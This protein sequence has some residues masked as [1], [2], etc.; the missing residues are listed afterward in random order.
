MLLA[1]FV[2]TAAA[3]P[4]A[5]AM[6]IAALSTLLTGCINSATLIRLKPDGS[7][8]IEQSTLVNT[9]AF[10]GAL[11]G[12]DAQGGRP[13]GPVINEADIKRQA[14]RMG[15]V[16]YVSSEPI[17]GPNGFEGTKTI[18]AFDDINQVRVDQD[19]NMSGSTSGTFGTPPSVKNPVLFALAKNGG[20]STLTVTFPDQAKTVPA[21]ADPAQGGPDMSN[22][23]MMA[24][25]K[26]LFDGF[27]VAIALEVDGSIV[28][29]NADYVS[30]NHITLLEMDLGKLLQDQEKLKQLQSK[31]R[32]GASI[33]EVKP[34]L[35]DVQG[36]KINEPVITV[37]FK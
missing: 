13:A 5:R 15:G 2:S 35:K 34:Y 18:Y 16:K 9:Q 7:G 14:E 11:G 24:M 4:V 29:T 31:V 1:R 6:S 21:G 27:K 23:Q 32:P 10:R 37:E 25:M 30:G 22:P 8:T 26:N 20:T 12:L 19:P 36:I 17:N 28:K 33:S 3:A